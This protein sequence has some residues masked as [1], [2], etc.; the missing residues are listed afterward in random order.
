MSW[1]SEV[2]G[3]MSRGRHLTE[4]H[5]TVKAAGERAQL[6][7]MKPEPQRDPWLALNLVR[8]IATA[9]HNVLG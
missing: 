4:F 8:D 5:D 1:L 6:E 3:L 7:L 9:T 2:L